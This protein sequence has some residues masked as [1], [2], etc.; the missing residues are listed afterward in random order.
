MFGASLE[1]LLREGE[2]ERGSS[3]VCDVSVLKV[4]AALSSVPTLT[5]M[6]FSE[7]FVQTSCP[8]SCSGSCKTRSEDGEI[9]AGCFVKVAVLC[10]GERWA[11]EPDTAYWITVHQLSQCL[12][13][14]SDCRVRQGSWSHFHWGISCPWFTVESQHAE[15]VADRPDKL[16]FW[17][18]HNANAKGPLP[19]HHASLCCSAFCILDQW[20]SVATEALLSLWNQEGQCVPPKAFTTVRVA[21]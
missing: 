2:T 8:L 6:Y 13:S 10:L 19:F 4:G 9:I 21:T 15:E 14:C 5:S 7:V 20:E 18:L 3:Q 17:L 11:H 16:V 12:G 1:S